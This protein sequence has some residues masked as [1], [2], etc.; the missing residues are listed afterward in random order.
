VCVN[1]ESG[2]QKAKQLRASCGVLLSTLERAAERAGYEVLSWQNLRGTKRPIDFAREGNVDVLFEINELDLATVDDS[3]LEHVFRFFIQD[4]GGPTRDLPVEGA[5]AQRCRELARS[6]DTDRDSQGI[7]GTID[8]K[9]V[10]VA[11]GRARWRYRKT[12]SKVS[13]RSFPIVWFD[14]TDGDP[15]TVLCDP[16]KLSALRVEVPPQQSG[17][18]SASTTFTEQ[19]GHDPLEHQREQIREEMLA[20]FNDVLREVHERR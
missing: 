16:L 14:A 1:A 5:T 2:D 13:A 10:T 11:D 20:Q 4:A 15:Q 3:S 7:T 6:R 8:I 19:T 9:M 12:L 17:P 18:A